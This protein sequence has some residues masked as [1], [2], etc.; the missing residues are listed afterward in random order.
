MSEELSAVLRIAASG[1]HAQSTRLRIVSENLANSQSTALGPELDPYR[2]KTITFSE[3]LNE[4]DGVSTVRVSGLGTDD[5]AFRIEHRPGHLAADDAGYVKLPN[6]NPLIEMADMREASRSY[7]A[8]LQV[9]K[10][11][12]EMLSGLIDLLRIR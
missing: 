7:Q 1:M 4:A 3:H 10:Q 5:S 8:N 11:A 9:M 6:V 12:R 2:R